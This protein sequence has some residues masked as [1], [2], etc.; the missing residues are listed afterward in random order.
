MALLF[1]PIWTRVQ[2]FLLLTFLL[3]HSV[4]ATPSNR[5]ID[6]TNGDSATGVLPQYSGSWNIGQNCP[7]CDLQPDPAG[8]FEGTWHDSTSGSTDM[9]TV[10]LSFEGEM[11]VTDVDVVSHR[12][13]TCFNRHCRL[14][15]LH[16]TQ[17]YHTAIL[18]ILRE[19]DE[20]RVG[21]CPGGLF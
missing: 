17:G 19:Y 6:D 3:T 2:A 14:G 8:A 12:K 7:G 1:T 18:P 15:S 5:T 9:H 21:W 4:C 11:S 20:L 13:R 10:T 16:P